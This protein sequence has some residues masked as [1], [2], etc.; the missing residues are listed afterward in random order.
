MLNL[1][2]ISRALGVPRISPPLL[3]LGGGAGER[4]WERGCS[5]AGRLYTGYSGAIMRKNN[6]A[7]R[8]GGLIIVKLLDRGKLFFVVTS[9]GIRNQRKSVISVP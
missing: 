7:E 2:L 8:N 3:A 9:R 1:L 5:E 4:S 6:V